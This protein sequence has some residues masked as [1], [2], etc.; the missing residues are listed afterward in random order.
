[1]KFSVIPFLIWATG[2]VSPT[3]F[4]LLSRSFIKWGPS[5]S[6]PISTEGY[7]SVLRLTVAVEYEKRLSSALSIIPTKSPVVVAVKYTLIVILGYEGVF[8]LVSAPHTNVAIPAK[9]NRSL[10]AYM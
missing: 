2:S 8:W 4:L 10:N 7:S 1:M 3:K 9:I 6:I 5:S